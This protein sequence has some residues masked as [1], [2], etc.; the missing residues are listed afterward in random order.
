MDYFYNV[1][2]IVLSWFPE[3]RCVVKVVWWKSDIGIRQI[4]RIFRITESMDNLH[5][6][7]ME[8]V[9]RC[10]IEKVEGLLRLNTGRFQGDRNENL[11]QLQ[12]LYVIFIFSHVRAISVPSSFNALLPTK[13]GE[14]KFWVFIFVF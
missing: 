14:G 7:G 3:R 12:S 10:I 2:S 11:K 4:L 8:T 5:C 13:K 6:L 9:M 1:P